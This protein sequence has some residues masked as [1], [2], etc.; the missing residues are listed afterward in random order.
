MSKHFNRG[1]MSNKIIGIHGNKRD[2]QSS[3][4]GHSFNSTTGCMDTIID[5]VV[6]ASHQIRE[7]APASESKWVVGSVTTLE[8]NYTKGESKW[9]K[10]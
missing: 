7:P 10:K 3:I 1:F 5:G 6:V 8:L 4:S 9:S 2:K